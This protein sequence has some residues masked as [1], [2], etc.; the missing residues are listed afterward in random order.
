MHKI[1]A[2]IT[3]LL[4]ITGLPREQVQAYADKG[5]LLPTGNHLGPDPDGRAQVE[6]GTWKYDAV[7]TLERYADDGPTLMAMIIGWLA[8]NDPDRDGLADP[9]LDVDLND[10]ITC[11]VQLSCEFEERLVIVADP[12][13]SI[14]FSGQM[15]R[16]ATP[17][18]RVATSLER[19]EGRRG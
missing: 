11:D 15:W 12:Q 4:A 6:V 2:L 9:E 10:G 5:E 18:E 19:M 1:S 3:H 7:I 14:P 8:D 13:G 16:M 17:V